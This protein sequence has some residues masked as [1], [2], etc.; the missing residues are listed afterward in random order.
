MANF[1]L[2][3]QAQ[4]H[5][6]NARI[7]GDRSVL[8]QSTLNAK[9]QALFRSQAAHPSALPLNSIKRTLS[10]PHPSWVEAIM[11]GW[12]TRYGVTQ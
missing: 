4:A 1:L 8:I 7:W 5:K 9:Q 2:S 6:Q 12:Q 10:E 11:Q 3:P